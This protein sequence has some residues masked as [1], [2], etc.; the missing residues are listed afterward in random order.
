MP[1]CPAAFRPNENIASREAVR[2]LEQA[3]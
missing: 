3:V 2:V 1:R